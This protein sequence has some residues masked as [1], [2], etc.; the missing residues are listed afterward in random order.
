MQQI[1]DGI[2]SS[3]NSLPN[4]EILLDESRSHS[5]AVTTNDTSSF[6][7]PEFFYDIQS[8]SFGAE[9]VRNIFYRKNLRNIYLLY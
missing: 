9:N 5:L 4:D 8:K 1:L 7:H 6:K 2:R 3:S